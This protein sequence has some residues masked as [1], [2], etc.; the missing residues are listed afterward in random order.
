MAYPE[1]KDIVAEGLDE[2]MTQWRDKPITVGLLKSYLEN[3]QIVE[4]NLQSISTM[5]SIA[6]SEGVQL[7]NL[8][9]IVGQPRKVVDGTY[10]LYFGFAG[11]PNAV[12]F[13]IEPFYVSG[14]PILVT[15]ELDDDQ[16]RIYIRA[17]AAS[18]KS[19]G[20]P[21]DLINFFKALFGA[22]TNTIVEDTD[23]AHAVVKVGHIF[24]ND[25]KL[26]ILSSKQN[27]IVP[28]PAGVSYTIEQFSEN[29]YFGFAADSQAEGFNVGSF[30]S[31]VGTI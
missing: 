8:G 21:E 24:T 15:K 6:D 27:G 28:R 18:N 19:S 22:E 16:Y 30:I 31:T 20:T 1:H 23:P 5:T 13:G 25:E 3:V 29:G 4:D 7:D 14:D 26:I 9:R 10:G 17:R 12:G 11:N 2:L